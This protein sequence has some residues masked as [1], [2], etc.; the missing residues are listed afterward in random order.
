M[1]FNIYLL[2]DV[3]QKL[4][5]LSKKIQT[6]NV[7][8]N[9]LGAQ[10]ELTTRSLT[11]MFLDAENFGGDSKYIKT[12]MEVAEDGI[13]EYRDKTGT[14]H[15]HTLFFQEI[16][17]CGDSGYT[18]DACKRLVEEYVQVVIDSLHVRFPNMRVFNATKISS[19]ISYHVELSLLYRNAHLWLQ[20]LLNHF[21]L[22]GCRLVNHNR[23]ISE[24]KSFVDTL[25][26]AC[27]GLK[28]HRAWAIFASTEDYLSRFP[29]MTQ[30]WQVILTLPTSTASCERGFSTQ[31]LIKSSG[32][33]ALNITT[34]DALTRIAMA[35]IPMESLDFEDVW[36][37][38]M[39]VKDKRFQE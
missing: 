25:Q 13:I 36:E 4:N 5:V 14:I 21:C 19:P 22:G 2:V 30:L 24:L 6:E 23:C 18:F 11:Q 12:F 20:V 37:R 32:R 16:P 29:H 17:S 3:L 31:N 38:W 1:M 7:D 28:M 33:C 8:L 10:I 39:S 15:N 26:V 9:Q 27:A 34:L 35:K